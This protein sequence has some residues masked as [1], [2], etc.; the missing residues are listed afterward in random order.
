MTTVHL[1]RVPA[2]LNPGGLWVRQCSE[3]RLI[4][5]HPLGFGE[6][7]SEQSGEIDRARADEL[8]EIG[9]VAFT[10][11]YDGDSGEC[12]ATLVTRP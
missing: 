5:E 3:Y 4:A 11:I 10:Y 9:L 2:R 12:L 1:L 6:L 8:A 7:T